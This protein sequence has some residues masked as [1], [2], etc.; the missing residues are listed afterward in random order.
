M[1]SPPALLVQG[2]TRT[3]GVGKRGIQDVSLRI[4]EG[5]IYGFLGPNGAGKTTAMRCIL[6]LI[7]RDAG[8]VEIFGD[9]DPISMRQHVGAIIETP[10]FHPWMSGWQNLEQSA[11][12]LGLPEHEIQQQVDRVLQ[13]VGLLERSRD[14]ASNYSLGMRQRLGIA[15]ALL[16]QPRLLVLDEPTN[17]LDPKGM[18]EVRDLVRSLAL[19]DGLTVF[20]SSHLLSEIQAIGTRVGILVEG[21]LR[22]EGRVQDL[23]ARGD[24]AP[25]VRISALDPQA[26]KR[27]VTEHVGAEIVEEDSQGSLDVRLVTGSVPELVRAMVDQ[28]I[29]LTRV[30]PQERSLEDAFLELTS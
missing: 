13:R 25:R 27:C 29:S 17:G 14:P 3:Y 26:L 12:Y 20:V 21:E 28:N 23:L 16:G 7:R 18:R 10:S 8:H 22:A 11:L 9:A 24:K 19:H 30:V 15:R 2:L 5:D 1:S 4:D 6:G